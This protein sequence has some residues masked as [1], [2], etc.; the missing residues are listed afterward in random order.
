M[1]RHLTSIRYQFLNPLKYN[2]NNNKGNIT[3]IFASEI[4]MH[5]VYLR[6]FPAL[7]LFDYILGQV[8][9]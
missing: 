7:Q 5:L 4:I 2:N 8:N 1:L 3:V 6:Y 9:D